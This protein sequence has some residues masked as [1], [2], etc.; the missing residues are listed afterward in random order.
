MNIRDQL[1]SHTNIVAEWKLQRSR[2][3]KST[4]PGIDDQSRDDFAS[5]IKSEAR[6]LSALIKSNNYTPSPLRPYAIPKGNSS[7]EIRLINVPTIRD[8]LVQRILLSFLA[9]VYGLSWNLPNSFNSMEGFGGVNSTLADVGKSLLFRDYVIK[10][11]LSKYFDRIDRSTLKETVSRK[12]RHRS[13]HDLMFSIIDCETSQRNSEHR[14]IFSKSGLKKGSGIRQ[15]MPL[16]PLFAY[17]FLM[18]I[19]IKMGRRFY[20]YVDDL[21]FIDESKKSVEEKFNSYRILAEGRGL[22]IHPF[23]SEKTVLF[24]PSENFEF[25]GLQIFRSAEGNTFRIPSK[26]KTKIIEKTIASCKVDENDKK[27][28]KN[29]V[30]SITQR[31]RGLVKDYKSA[32]GICTDWPEFE[33]VLIGRQIRMC[34]DII[35]EMTRIK[36][37]KDKEL[38][39]RIF[40]F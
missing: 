5:A 27:A 18:D 19:D 16:S 40:G 22:T 6:S 14:S 11:D 29:W 39:R 37:L 1:F 33:K 34:E 30:A 35:S 2:I 17:L 21:L 32:Y 4:A 24:G 36:K 3:K 9:K 38:L 12:I 20:R 10:A 15:G 26:S 8:R 25:L 31:A 23:G 28:N 7:D 13:L